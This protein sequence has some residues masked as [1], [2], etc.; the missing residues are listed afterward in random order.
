MKIRFYCQGIGD[1]H[2]LKFPKDGGGDFWMLI[3]CG[4]HSSITGGTEKIKAIVDDIASVTKRLD[5]IVLTHEHWDHVSGF[6]LAES[7]FK[8]FDVGEVWMAWTENPDDPQALQLDKFKGGALAALHQ[9]S[10]QLDQVTDLGPHLSAVQRGMQALLGFNFGAKGERV[11]S[12]RDAAAR[13]AKRSDVKYL[14]PKSPP[15]SPLGIAKSVR[16]YVL[17]PPRD[18]AMLGL[19]ERQSEM[20][21]MGI[22]GGWPIVRALGNAFAINK[23]T[24]L[25][26]DDATAPFDTPE[27]SDLSVVR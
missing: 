3:D 9:A 26:G 12:A 7:K 5:V 15:I 6:L 23:G 24:L 13:L 22:A 8:D 20:Y 4:I 21:G 17:G 10:Q 11:R 1:C 2:L 16:I 25:T 19:T 27:G 14:E 18:A